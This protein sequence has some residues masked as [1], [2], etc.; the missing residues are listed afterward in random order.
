M[1]TA[2]FWLALKIISSSG[3]QR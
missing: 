2:S 1:F 3:F